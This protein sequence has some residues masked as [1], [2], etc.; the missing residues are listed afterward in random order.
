[1]FHD[2]WADGGSDSGNYH[3]LIRNGQLLIDSEKKNTQSSLGEDKK[4]QQVQKTEMQRKYRL[5]SVVLVAVIVIALLSAF[6]LFSKQPPVE[7]GQQ[8]VEND[9]SATLEHVHVWQA[10]DCENAKQ[11]V[12]CGSVDGGP[13]GHDGTEANYQDH[14][15]CTYCGIVLGDPLQPDMEKYGITEFLEVGEIYS[16][17]TSTAQN[18]EKTTNG[19]LQILSYDVFK[20]AKGYPVKKGYEWHVVQVQI[21]FF[22]SNAKSWGASVGYCHENYYNVDLS[23]ATYS[24][25]EET[26]MSSR[27][28]SFHGKEIPIYYKESDSWSG[29]EVVDGRNQNSYFMVRAWLVPEGYD[30]AVIGFYNEHAVKWSDK[31]IYEVYDPAHFLL[32]RL[33]GMN[34]RHY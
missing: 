15:V 18:K 27:M 33:N 24:Y 23:D 8:L 2:Q 13:L 28:I 10:A 9:A 30:G 21:D 16:Y 6:L 11:C 31:H 5:V 22:D 12:D 7:A 32:F 14:S 17:T 25:D 1:M 34:P 29:W 19:E 26:D 4:P 20:S 3:Q